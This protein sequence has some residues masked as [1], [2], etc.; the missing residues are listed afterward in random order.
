LGSSDVVSGGVGD[1]TVVKLLS[2]T[3]RAE[4]TIYAM[5]TVAKL[6]VGVS[7]ATAG[8]RGGIA[9]PGIVGV[10]ATVTVI[11]YDVGVER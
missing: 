5:L 9:P 7:N 4:V 6:L 3:S 10:Q 1:L 11:K 2:G 8:G